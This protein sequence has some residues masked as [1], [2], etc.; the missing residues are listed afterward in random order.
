MGLHKYLH[1][2]I[3]RIAKS[4]ASNKLQ[5][6]STTAVHSIRP[7]LPRAALSSIRAVRPTTAFARR[8]LSRSLSRAKPFRPQLIALSAA[9]GIGAT[10]YLL[11]RT[12]YA[13]APSPK[14]QNRI[15]G[16][17]PVEQTKV[18]EQSDE[19]QP[20]VE[21]S[22]PPANA[23]QDTSNPSQP[24][25]NSKSMV[26]KSGSEGET[27]HKLNEEGADSE[28]ENGEEEGAEGPYGS[29]QEDSVNDR[30][31]DR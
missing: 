5:V 9:F 20:E 4:S 27:T 19:G 18:Q 7:M 22:T 12:T 13:E 11:S 15:K 24:S 2:E 30:P 29:F 1:C 8:N 16:A 3:S 31:R 17:K 21:Q 25:A 6:L 26:E 28:N 10:F 23:Q 14:H